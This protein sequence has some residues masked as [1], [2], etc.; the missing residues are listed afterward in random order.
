VFICTKLTML[1]WNFPR[2][3]NVKTC[4]ICK[5]KQNTACMY[6]CGSYEKWGVCGV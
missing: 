3:K 6:V 1:A 2:W 5:K 4:R